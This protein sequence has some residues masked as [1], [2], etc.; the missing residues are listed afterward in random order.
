MRGR[1]A[2]RFLRSFGKYICKGIARWLVHRDPPGW[3]DIGLPE[4]IR[5]LR[6]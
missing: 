5:Q 1:F 3:Q 4:L 2:E 6:L